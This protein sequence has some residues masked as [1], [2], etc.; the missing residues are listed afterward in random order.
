VTVLRKYAF[1]WPSL[2]PLWPSLSK[3]LN[4]HPRLLS[5][6]QEV[7]ST[8]AKKGNFAEFVAVHVRRT[9]YV[10]YVQR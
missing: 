3:Q 5:K 1:D 4:F 6:S 10:K 9:D 2:L 8:V 7:L